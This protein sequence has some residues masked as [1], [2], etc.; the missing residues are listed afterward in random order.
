MCFPS[1]AIRKPAFCNART[2]SRWLTPG[3]F[4]TLTADFDLPDLP[5]LHELL[6][7]EEIFANCVLDILQCL[8]FGSAFGPT[9]RQS[10]ARHG[11][12]LIALL[13]QDLIFHGCSLRDLS[14]IDHKLEQVAVWIAHV[15]A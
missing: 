7:N 11:N 13:Q 9:T 2:A 8:V 10:R 12:S 1:R 3:I 14:R 6:A 5:F 15:G 4:G